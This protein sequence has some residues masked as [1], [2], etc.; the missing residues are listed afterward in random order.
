VLD[1]EENYDAY[2]NKE[3]GGSERQQDEDFGGSKEYRV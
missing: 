3:C 2:G 1:K